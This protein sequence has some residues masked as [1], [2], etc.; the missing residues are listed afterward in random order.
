[1]KVVLDSNVLLVAIGKQSRFR[2]IWDAFIDGK[3]SLILSEDILHEY[4]E[5]LNI[6]AAEGATEIVLETFIESP[7]IIFK[8]IY[9]YWNAITNDPDDNKFFDIAFAANA[10]YLVTDDKHFDVAKTIAFP[11][12]NIISSKDFLLIIQSISL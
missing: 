9:Y 1:M 10:D 4:E 6:Y 8:R 3:F 11:S 7:D 12:V 5:I 2:P